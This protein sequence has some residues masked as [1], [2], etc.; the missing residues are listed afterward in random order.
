MLPL[1]INDRFYN[2]LPADP[3]RTQSRR[4]VKAACYS[5][6][7]PRIPGN[8][9]L[10]HASKEA[11]DLIGLSEEDLKSKN[12]LDI[13]SGTKKMEGT[14]PYA[15]CYGGH[16]FGHWAGQ[17]GDGRAINI[18]EVEHDGKTWAL[19]LKGS[20]ETPYSRTAD[21]LAVLRSS[22]REHLCS[23]AMYHLGVPTTRSLSLIETGDQVMRDMLYDG[24][25]AYEK[26]AVVCRMAPAFIRFGNFEILASRRDV[27][28]LRKLT[29][30]TIK[31]FYPEIK[32]GTADAYVE[33]LRQV[34]RRTLT[35]IMDW[36]RVG[37]VHGVMNTDNMSILGLT[38][39]YGPYGWLEGYEPGWTP[40][41]TDRQNKRYQ[42]GQ[43][44]QMA[45]WNIYQLA[46]A[47]YPLIEATEPLEAVLNEFRDNY[48]VEY[49]AM[50]RKKL[51]LAKEEETDWNLIKQL[52]ETLQLIETDM[53]IF[54]RL[55][56]KFSIDEVSKKD[57][58]FLDLM[59]PAFYKVEALTPEIKQKWNDWAQAYADRLSRETQS[60]D[61][62]Q[63]GMNLVNPKYVLRNY[64]SQLAIDQ[65]NE[66][67]YELIDE[68]YQLLKQPYAE[69]PESEKW[70][71]KRP[72]WARH[73]VGCSMLSCSS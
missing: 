58:Y 38:I 17:L 47:L 20:G 66:G 19:Q 61:A 67:N 13:F 28:T 9:T 29:D 65:A 27:E 35:M 11:A 34:A 37:F 71:A 62:R 72:E 59:E 39:D 69:Q 10:V 60:E 23:E 46:N 22:V 15:M 30:F 2:E 8:P 21:G 49:P 14:D 32:V 24:N 5:Y 64:M 41:T 33:F 48:S 56:S 51:G 4:Q 52:E 12:F 31:Y 3:E 1:K 55:L 44:A 16:Q 43:Q 73:K 25:A 54:F 36:Q 53:T 6:A 26:G 42:Y 18:G 7:T 57:S 40:N 45:H 50:M 63:I 68:L 70:F